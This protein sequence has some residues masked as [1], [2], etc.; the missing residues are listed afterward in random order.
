ML[1]RFIR[2]TG[3][4]VADDGIGLTMGVGAALMV[5]FAAVD[6]DILQGKKQAFNGEG[7]L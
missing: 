3:T 7:G 5:G 2:G 1:E 6:L 4:Y